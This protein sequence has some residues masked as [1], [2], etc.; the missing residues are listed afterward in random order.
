VGCGAAGV[1]TIELARSHF[2]AAFK[3]GAQT[4]LKALIKSKEG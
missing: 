3:A 4:M 2:F 1:S